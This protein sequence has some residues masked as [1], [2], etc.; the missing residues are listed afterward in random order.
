MRII[1]I[2]IVVLAIFAQAESYRRFGKKFKLSKKYSLKKISARHKLGRTIHLGGNKATTG[3]SQQV[4]TSGNG[5]CFKH[6]APD[7]TLKILMGS[8]H[9]TIPCQECNSATLVNVNGIQ[10]NLAYSKLHMVC[11]G[12]NTN[13]LCAAWTAS[14][15]TFTNNV[16]ACPAQCDCT[17]TF[18]T[19]QTYEHNDASNRAVRYTASCSAS[20]GYRY[21]VERKHNNA[22]IP[23][24]TNYLP[25]TTTVGGSTTPSGSVGSTNTNGGGTSGTNSVGF[26]RRRRLLQ[27]QQDS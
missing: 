15:C 19:P 10:T 22:W 25:Y 4:G 16:I 8:S 6:F 7:K 11:G 27:S 9:F 14:G 21:S 1:F 17:D 23:V 12:S 5:R 20:H 24:S 3:T 13:E 2:A 18:D 26:N